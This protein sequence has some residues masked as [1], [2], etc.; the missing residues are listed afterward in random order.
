MAHALLGAIEAYATGNNVAAGAAGAVSG[1]LAAKIIT[2]K[3]YQTNPENLTES[4]KQ[5]VSTLSQL[6]SGLAGG[7]VG[8]STSSAISAA[9]IGKRA[10]EDNF[11]SEKEITILD[12]LAQKKVLTPEDVELI[13]SI[14]MKDKVSDALL[15]KYQKAPTSLTPQEH[16]QLVYWVNEAAAWQP[17]TAKNILKMD[18]TGA[19]IKYSTP[20]LEK[21]YQAAHRIYSSLD[22]QFGKSTL[23]GLAV[24]GNSGNAIIKGVTTVE[25][26]ARGIS[27]KAFIT[28]L[29]AEKAANKLSPLI[30]EGIYYS[31]NPYSTAMTKSIGEGIESIS[32][33]TPKQYFNGVLIGSGTN[34]GAQYFVNGKIDYSEALKPGLS[35]PY[36]IYTPIGTSLILG[37]ALTAID[38]KLS[39]NG[40]TYLEDQNKYLRSTILGNLI[41]NTLPKNIRNST[42]GIIINNFSG[43]VINQDK[44]EVD[45]NE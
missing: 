34:I 3:L 2:E 42:F 17:E 25:T 22:Y 26:L 10:V 39:N 29:Q 16:Q 9:E 30:S 45:K 43:E 6:A 27:D 28:A 4:Q 13:M 24:L 21:K 19:A 41:Q 5:T 7:L 38:T 36:L 40:N 33:I 11:L 1:E 12:K 32:K 23:E 31:Y 37:N 15:T 14:K 44:K 8:D 18:V 20:E 35:T